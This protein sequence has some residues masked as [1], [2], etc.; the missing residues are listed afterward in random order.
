MKKT[1]VFLL[2]VFSFCCKLFS[3]DDEAT[4]YLGA[5]FHAARRDSLRK[6]MPAN[7]VMAI[8]AFPARTY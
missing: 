5:S 4:D 7:S 2:L 1:F 6:M 3:Q 8:F